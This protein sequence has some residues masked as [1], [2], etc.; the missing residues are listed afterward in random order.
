MGAPL[1]WKWWQCLGNSLPGRCAPQSLSPAP[2]ESSTGL[3]Q[4]INP[5]PPP[6]GLGRIRHPLLCPKC[7]TSAL[8]LTSRAPEWAAGRTAW[9][10]AERQAAA[11]P[12]EPLAKHPQSR[13]RQR[14][15]QAQM[16]VGRGDSEEGLVSLAERTRPGCQ[17][18]T[19]LPRPWGWHAEKPSTLSVRRRSLGSQALGQRTGERPGQ[20]PCKAGTTGRGA[21]SKSPLTPTP[22]PAT[23]SA[24]PT[25]P[26]RASMKLGG[27]GGR[28]CPVREPGG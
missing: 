5:P 2:E 14:T 4:T 27:G 6:A 13:G 11:P 3:V 19:V 22:T 8:P 24:W 21:G 1:L 18:P 28:R 23:G 20:P 26:P 15:T 7:P 16:A 17:G 12:A 10:R 9:R 25:Q